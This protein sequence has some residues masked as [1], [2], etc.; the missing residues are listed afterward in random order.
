MTLTLPRPPRGM[1][2]NVA[3]YLER[4]ALSVEQADALNW[5]KNADQTFNFQLFLTS[6][7]TGITAS[8]TQSQGQQPLT[9]MINIVDTVSVANDVVT[10]PPASEGRL[11]FVR[12]NDAN[13]LQIFPASGDAIDDNTVDTSIS[14][15]G[16]SG[17]ILIAVDDTNWYTMGAT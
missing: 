15:P 4:L 11:V 16:T 6:I 3:R 9:A 14:E 10:L 7:E 17:L 13:A 5:K 12:D 2:P 1:N 8:G